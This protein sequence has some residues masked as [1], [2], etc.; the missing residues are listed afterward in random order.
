ML[1]TPGGH[2]GSHGP[3]LANELLVAEKYFIF[4]VSSGDENDGFQEVGLIGEKYIAV[5]MKVEVGREGPRRQSRR[6]K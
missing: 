3:S 4:V 5:E 6:F 1:P 2:G